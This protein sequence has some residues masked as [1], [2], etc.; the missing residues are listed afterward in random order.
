LQATHLV[1]KKE[2]VTSSTPLVFSAVL[3]TVFSLVLSG[4]ISARR[5]P[6]LEHIFA[7][8]RA[9]TGKR[10]VIIIPGILGSELINSKTGE[11][12]WP[13]AFRTADDGLPMTPDLVNNHDDLVPGK[14]VE[15]VRLARILPEVFVYRDLLEALRHYAGYRDGDW[16]NPGTDGDKDTFYVFAYDWRQD[17]VANARELIRRIEHLKEKLQRPDLR[18]NIVAHSMGGL[19]AR[20]AAMYGNTDLPGDNEAIHPTWAGAAHIN[21]IVMIGVPNEGSADAFATLVEGYSITEGLRRRVPLLNKLTAEDS[22]S[23][24]ALFQLLPHASAVR[25]LDENLK[26]VQVDLYEPEVWKHYG[27]S[28]ISNPDFRRRYSARGGGEGA[29]LQSLDAYFVAV[30]KRALRFHQT[31]DASSLVNPPVSLMAIGGDCE[32]TLNSPVILHD[33]KQDRFLT[34]IRPREYRTTSGLRITRAQVT[35]AMYAPGD[36]RV[37]RASLLGAD[38][39]KSSKESNA[40]NPGLR[41]TYAV[42]GCDLHGQLQRNKTLQDNALTAIVSEAM[43]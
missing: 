29:R 3:L 25:F 11:K 34:L 21:K 42:F 14:I 30:L 40:D 26:P 35:A 20:Y 43:K 10:P 2:R 5:S 39:S 31:L 41:L 12:V 19:I 37:T 33:A 36:G 27:W 4:C 17:N 24:P 18:F 23:S 13:S 9:T 1:V 16:N 15:T 28:P 8:A 38:L 22:I 6:N 7:I 32:E